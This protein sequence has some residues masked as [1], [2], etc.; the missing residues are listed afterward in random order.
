MSL[1]EVRLCLPGTCAPFPGRRS[2]RWRCCMSGIHR[3]WSYRASVTFCGSSASSASGPGRFSAIHTNRLCPIPPRS[4]CRI[5]EGP[6][7]FGFGVRTSC[8]VSC[9]PTAGLVPGSWPDSMP[10][11]RPSLVCRGCRGGRS[12]RFRPEADSRRALRF[13]F[14]G[15]CRRAPTAVRLPFRRVRTR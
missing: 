10:G 8:R 4:S 6:S 9:R 11:L 3:R 1:A 14:S 13:C 15:S 7:P 12:S 5:R 2:S